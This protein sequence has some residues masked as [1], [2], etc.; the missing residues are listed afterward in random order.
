[1]ERSGRD[2]AISRI[3]VL[4]YVAGDIQRLGYNQAA[5][6]NRVHEEGPFPKEK[7]RQ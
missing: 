3:P 1:M 6:D 2:E 5:E 4:K 7:Y